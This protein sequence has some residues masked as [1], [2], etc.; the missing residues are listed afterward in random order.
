MFYIVSYM[1][2][3][4]KLFFTCLVLLAL[5][6]F[7][8]FAPKQTLA[9][10]KILD[11]STAPG[12]YQITKVYDGDTFAISMDGRLE[13]VRLI[14]VDTPETHK[15]NSPVECFGEAAS[16]FSKKT[17]TG[18]SVRLESD[19]TNQNRDR[20]QRLLRYAYL[21][22]GTLYNKKLIDEGYGFAYLSFPFTKAD[23][24]RNAQTAARQANKGLWAGDCQ[25]ND[26]NGRNKTNA[27]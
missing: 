13:K 12:T 19:P 25:I 24:F 23:E 4:K 16:E 9:P 27:I 3:Y 5:A 2:K 15:P 1:V 22:D 21:S 18:Q 20:Y 10:A 11:T 7:S 6:I 17:L 26:I 8:Y 14:G